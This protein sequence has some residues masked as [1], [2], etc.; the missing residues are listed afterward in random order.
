VLMFAAALLAL[1][2]LQSVSALVVSY[3]IYLAWS[4][5]ASI[6]ARNLP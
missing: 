6:F 5:P 2:G 4:F 3:E 1:V